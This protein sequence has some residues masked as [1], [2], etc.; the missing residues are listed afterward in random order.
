[1]LERGAGLDT[2]AALWH[3]PIKSNDLALIMK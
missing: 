3:K 2:V 1:M